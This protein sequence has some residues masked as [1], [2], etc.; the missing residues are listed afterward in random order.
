MLFSLV[1]CS[2]IVG[3][4][5]CLSEGGVD[6]TVKVSPSP[7]CLPQVAGVFLSG[8]VWLPW[9]LLTLSS[10]P[11]RRVGGWWLMSAALSPSLSTEPGPCAGSSVLPGCGLSS[12]SWCQGLSAGAG[13]DLLHH[14]QA[15]ALPPP[16]PRAS[17]GWSGGG[18]FNCFGQGSEARWAFWCGQQ[19]GE[20]SG[21]GQWSG[22]HP[23]GHRWGVSWV[24]PLLASTRLSSSF[25]ASQM[26]SL[27]LLS[28]VLVF[29]AEVGVA[30]LVASAGAL[31]GVGS[32]V[33]SAH[34]P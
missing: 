29:G 31:G 32:Q 4:A 20:C 33:C 22:G 28:C 24:S 21:G 25:L 26:S 2:A 5:P 13:A 17:V 7:V 8:S 34:H 30:V 11:P 10:L 19:L 1:F 23:A 16:R 27:C 15:P 3:M 14:R 12:R 9:Q 6:G 18:A